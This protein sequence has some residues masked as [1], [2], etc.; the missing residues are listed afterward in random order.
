MPKR[1]LVLHAVSLLSIAAAPLVA[2]AADDAAQDAKDKPKARKTPAIQVLEETPR[3]PSQ[4]A[5]RLAIGDEAPALDI[6]HWFSG[7][8]DDRDAMATFEDGQIYV[9]EFWAT[10]CGPCVTQMPHIAEIQQQYADDLTVISVSD[11]SVVRIEQFLEREVPNDEE[12]R[13]Y[14]ELTSAYALATDPDESVY[15]DYMRAAG[16]NGIPTAFVVGKTGEIEWIGHPAVIEEPIEKLIDGTWNRDAYREQRE[17]MTELQTVVRNGRLSPEEQLAKLDALAERATEPRAVATIAFYR[18]QIKSQV[19]VGKALAG[20]EAARQELL[21]GITD[22]PESMQTIVMSVIQASSG[23]V[24]KI[25]PELLDAIEARGEE[26][27]ETE[28]T[29]NLNLLQLALF[30]NDTDRAAKLLAAVREVE[31]F[32]TMGGF[33]DRIEQQLEL[34]KASQLRQAEAKKA[35]GKKAKAEADGKSVEDAKTKSD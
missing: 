28:P 17:I 11:E 23:D 16:E 2:V 31:A 34:M 20:D 12:E 5:K 7:E 29:F 25:D 1:F 8:K 26:M 3:K 13:T 32:S 19:V 4:P 27:A 9:V 18:S 22:D 24:S 21:D 30:R 15:R 10:W 33:F 14:G 35:A 6:E